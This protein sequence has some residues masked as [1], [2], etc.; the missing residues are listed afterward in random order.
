MDVVR[1]KEVIGALSDDELRES[2]DRS[3]HS[4]LETSRGCSM[5]ACSLD[6]DLNSS[7]HL[8]A[9]EMR[10]RERLVCFLAQRMCRDDVFLF[11]HFQY[12]LAGDEC[13]SLKTRTWLHLRL[14]KKEFWEIRF[15]R[16]HT[17]VVLWNSTSSIIHVLLLVYRRRHHDNLTFAFKGE[18]SGQHLWA[19]SERRRASKSGACRGR[20]ERSPGYT[21]THNE[22][23]P[24]PTV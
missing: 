12:T 8:T 23:M 10:V 19:W 24:Q 9:R 22:I 7:H 6:E 14:V 2:R 18:L 13:Q 21:E 5:R 16:L 15:K 11:L 1:E 17:H 4:A 20:A 3:C